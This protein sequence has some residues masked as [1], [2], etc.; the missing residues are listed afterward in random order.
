M[1]T[2]MITGAGGTLG[3]GIVRCLAEEQRQRV[4][5]VVSGRRSVRFPDGVVT[6]QAD[7]LE[8]KE[9]LALLE[10]VKPDAILHLAWSLEGAGFLGSEKNIQ[11]LE[12]SLA[13]L[14]SCACEAFFFAGSSAEYG[15]GRACRETDACRPESLYG[16]CKLAFERTAARFCEERGTRFV[17]MRFFSVYG[18]EDKRPGRAL[19]T[20]IQSF[21]RG[22]PFVCKGPNNVWD[23]IYAEDVGRA[24]AR[25]V[26][27]RYTGAVNVSSG[28]AVTMREVFTA[29]ASILGAEALLRFDNEDQPGQWLSGDNR[30]LKDELGF[31]GFTPLEEGLRKTVEAWRRSLG[32]TR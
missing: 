7:L 29:L 21:L 11:W 19:P 3:T 17:G 14:R 31:D 23:Y 15:R 18:P 13:L 22:E 2:L 1:K 4:V 12:A 20:A 8:E 9:R 5:A 6:E 24:V 30:I 26:Q 28:Q 10:R 32:Q 16:E 25:I 27:S